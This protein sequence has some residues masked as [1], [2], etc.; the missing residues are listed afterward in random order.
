M[1]RYFVLLILIALFFS[2]CRQVIEEPPPVTEEPSIETPPDRGT[3]TV[4]KGVSFSPRSPTAAD[5]TD[6]FQ[7]A[8]EAG[9]AITWAGDW[10]ELA[11]DTG[12]PK[13]VTGLAANYGYIPIIEATFHSNGKSIRPLD[14]EVRRHYKDIAVAYAEKYQ[15]A[16]LG[17]GIEVNAVYRESPADFE[18]F[19]ELYNETYRL[20]KEKSPE[21]KVFTVF[22]LEEMKGHT[23]WS[24]AP[25]DPAKA[26]WSLPDKF[27]ADIVA[28]TTYPGLAYKDP[29][30]IPDDY[31]L[32]IASHTSKPVAFTE[33]GWH[34][35]DFPPGWESSE[36]EQA[37]FVER[38]FA[39]TEK[40]DRTILIWSFLYDPNAV[41]P[42]NS[43]GLLRADGIPTPAWD[44]WTGE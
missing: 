29:S 33:I 13:V 37:R 38:F 28:F 10:N 42:F 21:T 11:A 39:L 3:P 24:T 23:Y 25:A 17:L 9:D 36:E 44:T 27:Q 26:Q 18:V 8:T 32:E 22:Q 41:E 19:V 6:F 7:R 5:F 14:D 12:G 4:L 1:K 15:P 16:Y 40:L 2:G 31:Y 43:M 34:S 30:E 20:I 35:T